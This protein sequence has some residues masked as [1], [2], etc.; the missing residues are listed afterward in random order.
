[1]QTLR[2]ILTKERVPSVQGLIRKRS[3]SRPFSLR[4]LLSHRFSPPLHG[5]KFDNQFTNDFI[6]ALDIR[7]NGLCGGMSYTTLDYY[8]AFLPAPIQPFRPANGTVLHSYLYDRQVTSIESNIDKW[9]ELGFNPGGAR[10]TEFFNWGISAKPGE[11]I[12]ELRQFLDNGTP[13]VLGLQGD[14][15]TGNHQVIAFGYH[16]GRY[17]G[18]LGAHIEDFYILICDPNY[19]GLSRTLIADVGRQI[20][21]YREGGSETWRTYFVDKNYHAQQ[22][23]A[24]GNANFPMDNLVYELVLKFFTGGDDLRGGNDNLDLVVNLTDGSNHVYRNINL[25]SRWVVNNNE[26]AEVRLESPVRVEQLQSIVISDTFSRG[27]GGDN[28]NM[29]SLEIYVLG[30]GPLYREIK[31]VGSKRF[32]GDDKTLIVPLQ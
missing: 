14:G 29:D 22:P 10:D 11:R 9:T 7:T 1:M 32:T 3:L 25:G 23:P 30:G 12:D 28:W 18:D 5:F 8:F 19:P 31:R 20:Y 4:G 13:C 16:M 26:S 27:P 15:S 24:I 21:H 17:Q 2:P 6:P